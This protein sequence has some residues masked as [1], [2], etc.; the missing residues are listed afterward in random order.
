MLDE[1]ASAL[2]EKINTLCSDGSYKIVEADELLSAL[3]S[4]LSSDA[5]ALSQTLRYLAEH[6]YI[7]IKYAEG[8]VYCLCPLPGGRM[9]FENVKVAKSSSFRRRRDTVLLTALGAFLGAFLGSVVVW[10]MI[11]YLF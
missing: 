4:S 3:P 1:R 10:L 11:T 9:Y 6:D 8:D 2:L 5:E 7:N